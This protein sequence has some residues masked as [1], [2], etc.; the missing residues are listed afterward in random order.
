M[1]GVLVVL[2]LLLA[3][4][5]SAEEGQGPRVRVEPASFDFGRVLP[6]R[7]LRKE[8]RLRNLGDDALIIERISKSCGCTTAAAD[9][10]TLDPGQTTTLLVEVRTPAATGKI[11]HEV[12]VR[13]NDPETPA[14]QIRLSAV[15]VAEPK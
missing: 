13:S 5:S 15:V 6:G 7:T 1:R 8:F 3:M 12:L 10:S 2:A 11:E 9:D 14:L 4:V